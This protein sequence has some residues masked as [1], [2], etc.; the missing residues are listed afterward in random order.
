[1]H[2]DW[3]G[4]MTITWAD[5]VPIP[6]LSI[7]SFLFPCAFSF[8]SFVYSTLPPLT[9]SLCLSSSLIFTV[10]GPQVVLCYFVSQG[11]LSIANL[12]FLLLFL[13]AQWLQAKSHQLVHQSDIPSI[14]SP[15]QAYGYEEDALGVLH[16]QHPP[17]R[18]STL[19]PAYYNTLLVR[20]KA[21][22][23]ALSCW[24]LNVH[25]SENVKCS[26][27][28]A[29]VLSLVCECVSECTYFACQARSISVRQI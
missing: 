10:Y 27:V 19:G 8:L 6:T 15:G 1:M 7:L 11:I 23:Y 17:P 22:I 28:H 21:H 25:P 13:S 12:D 14:P 2:F 18:D 29:C 9:S 24:S 20:T 16:K 3:D 5:I 4:I 26:F